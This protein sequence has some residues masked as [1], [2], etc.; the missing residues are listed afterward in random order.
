M[1]LPYYVWK[2]IIKSN[3][4]IC[5]VVTPTKAQESKLHQ[6]IPASIFLLPSALSRYSV[7]SKSSPSC[8]ET[9][10]HKGTKSSPN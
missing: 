8:R 9:F 10:M 4:Q 7:E 3:I 2:K 5:S 6:R 1:P